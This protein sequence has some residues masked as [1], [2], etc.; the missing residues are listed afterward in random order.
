MTSIRRFF[1]FGLTFLSLGFYG[2]VFSAPDFSIS[3]ARLFT[4]TL[5]AIDRYYIDAERVNPTQMLIEALNSMQ[6]EVPEILVVFDGEKSAAVTV[7]VA[8]KLFTIKGIKSLKKLE[9]KT[10][11]ILSFI[12]LHYN[13]D[14]DLK[15]IEY[16]A[17]SGILSTLDPHSMFLNPEVFKEFKVGTKGEFGGLGIVISIRDGNLTVIAPLEG[18]PASKAGIKAGDKIVQI[19][20]E[21]SI[22]M[23][24]IDA[25]NRLRGKVGTSIRIVI[26]R[27]GISAPLSYMLT[28][29]LIN[30]DSVQHELIEDS[31]KRFGYL[32]IMNF[33][34]NTDEDVGKALE[35]FT[36]KGRLD[37]LILD[38]RNNPGGLL[39]QAVVI[40]DRFLSK[41]T[42]VSTVERGGSVMGVDEAKE[43]KNDLSQIPMVVLINEGAASASEIVAGA[44]RE[45]GRAVIVGRRSYGKGS[46]QTILEVGGESAVKLTIG[47]Y[48]PAGTYPI[49]SVGLSPDI[50]L[51]PVI[52]DKDQ[53]DLIENKILSEKDL[54]KHLKGEGNLE[55]ALYKMRYLMPKEDEIGKEIGSDEYTEKPKIADDLAVNLSRK[56]LVA[57]G[58]SD[59]KAVLDNA[60]KVIEDESKNEGNKIVAALKGLGVNWTD[61]VFDEKPD[62]VMNL[63]V[64]DEKG[65]IKDINAGQ[66]VKLELSIKNNGKA[67]I[68][69]LIAVSSSKSIFLDGKEFLFGMLNPGEVKKWSVPIEMPGYLPNEELLMDFALQ[70]G[71]KDLPVKA[72][73][74]LSVKGVLPPRFAVSSKL[75][76]NSVKPGEVLHIDVEV[77]NVGE[78]A[79]DKE[80]VVALSNKSGEEVFIETG[81]I[82]LGEMAPGESR[83]GTLEFHYQPDFSK[84]KIEMELSVLDSAHLV[85]LNQKLNLEIK[86]SVLT[87]PSGEFYEAPVISMES[88][89][90]HTKVANLSLTGRINDKTGVRDY[91]VFV[92]DKKIAYK[93][94]PSGSGGL[95]LNVNLSLEPGNNIIVVTARDTDG[96]QGRVL[97]SINRFSDLDKSAVNI[98][99]KA[100]QATN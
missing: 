57:A 56:I 44:L 49:Q 62:L 70:S 9:S 6:R 92:G 60:A 3:E 23:S 29:A 87:P 12:E 7:G 31:G 69:R 58:L 90:V 13:G 41:G 97:M 16:A 36:G 43:S 38:L 45:L 24:L 81:R 100:F 96:L 19:G 25:V 82:R 46:L 4:N 33:Q 55:E 95:K 50:E 28:R 98:T 89:P 22:N 78:G 64:K 18:T 51:V 76:E 94:N 32:R 26:E 61:G 15:D 86:G 77:K 99:P 59:R 2:R 93:P 14:I 39:T 10:R 72:Y 73:G 17:V 68:P 75:R 5:Y 85:T 47:E 83:K 21:S 30:I 80:T 74:I 40:S 34:S 1:I 84:D 48:L 27:P 37:G 35:D 52:V 42:I 53:I 71:G 65:I 88:S 91:F 54:D 67:A 63:E 66:K 79:S 8:T 20:D 11:E